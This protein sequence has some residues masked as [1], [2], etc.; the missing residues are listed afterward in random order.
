MNI[1]PL[2]RVFFGEVH[3][4][5]D[6]KQAM[7][8]AWRKTAGTDAASD[9]DLNQPTVGTISTQRF[10]DVAKVV[11][12]RANQPTPHNDGCIRIP[13]TLQLNFDKNRKIPI[14]INGKRK[15]VLIDIGLKSPLLAV[16]SDAWQPLED[17]IFRRPKQPRM[18][19]GHFPDSVVLLAEQDLSAGVLVGDPL[20]GE[21]YVMM[22][23]MAPDADGRI[24]FAVLSDAEGFHV[25][26]SGKPQSSRLKAAVMAALFASAIP[27]DDEWL[28]VESTWVDPVVKRG[29]GL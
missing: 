20:E 28:V 18:K 1:T 23:R 2:L 3:D 5:A 15:E 21:S 12:L 13:I 25:T 11:Y 27:R 6:A 7:L 22:E 10:S 17:S 4:Y 19:R 29:D 26:P 24:T 9:P 14:S 16:K 8:I